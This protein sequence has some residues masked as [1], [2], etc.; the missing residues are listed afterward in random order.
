MLATY[1]APDLD[2]A[3][4]E[5]LRAFIDKRMEDLPDSEY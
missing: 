5:K 4:D 1:S 3:I 2:P